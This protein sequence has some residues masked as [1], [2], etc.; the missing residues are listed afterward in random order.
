M[1]VGEV[2]T[3]G[4]A[5]AENVIV[6]QVTNSTTVRVQNIVNSHTNGTTITLLSQRDS[7]IQKFTIWAQGIQQQS[8]GGTQN[9]GMKMSNYYWGNMRNEFEI[10]VITYGDN[11]SG[12]GS[13]PDNLID[14]ALVNR[15]TNQIVANAGANGSLSGGIPQEGMEYGAAQFQYMIIPFF[16]AKDMG[17]DLILETPFMKQLLY[18]ALYSTTPSKT[19]I[20]DVTPNITEYF[21]STWSDDEITASGGGILWARAYIEDG[22]NTMAQLFATNSPS[23]NLGPYARQYLNT[24]GISIPLN[25][26]PYATGTRAYY[27]SNFLQAADPGGSA[28]SYSS[29]PL[30]YYATGYQA[31]I[32]KKAWDTSSSFVFYQF[33]KPADSVVGHAHSDFGNFDIWR[34][35]RYLSRKTISYNNIIAGEPNIN[36]N[37]N[38]SDVVSSLQ[39]NVIAFTNIALGQDSN[40]SYTMPSIR[41]G[42]PVVTRLESN[43]DYGYVASDLTN[44]Y[45]WDAGHSSFDTGVVGSVV[46]EMIYIRSLETLVVFDRVVTANQTHGGSLTAAQV[47]TSALHHYEVAP[48]QDGGASDYNHWT[49]TNGTQVLR[50]TVLIPAGLTASNARLIDEAS[51]A[52]CDAVGQM[53]LDIDNSGVATRYHLSVLQ[54]RDTSGTNHAVGFTDSNSGDPTLGTFTITTTPSGGS[55][56]TIVFNKGASSSGGTIAVA[57]GSTQSPRSDV[58]GITYTD[59]GPVW[60]IPVTPSVSFQGAKVQ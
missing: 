35:G 52:G 22:M 21:I 18:W 20:K 37:A 10:G 59:N 13:A 44:V 24:L 26:D 16:S 2:L 31:G 5:G 8:W 51:C 3:L 17:R 48:V 9:G 54:A 47:V 39:N 50:Q 27:V 56:T 43:A 45:K 55:A 11:G 4:S 38:Q 34:N 49:S 29:L 53:R 12:P 1:F 33:S 42:D 40:P 15:W 46:R 19:L 58:Q 28:G 14:N 57:G 41:L 23:T 30:D 25:L 7:F 32:W 60:S 36:A 6:D